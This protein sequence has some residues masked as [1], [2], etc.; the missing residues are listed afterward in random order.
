M[1]F[2]VEIP[3]A[4]LDHWKLNP[5]TIAAH[6]REELQASGGLYPPGEAEHVILSNVKVSP[7]NTR[8]SARAGN[9]ADNR[10][11]AP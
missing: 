10:S 1:K 8:P 2:I 3:K 11:N 4:D 9:R 5:V 6:I 7:L